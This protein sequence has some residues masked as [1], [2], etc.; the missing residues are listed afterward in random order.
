M[1]TPFT[2]REPDFTIL[3]AEEQLGTMRLNRLY[4]EWREATVE[5]NPPPASFID[6]QLHAYLAGMQMIFDVVRSDDRLRFRYRHVG[7]H[8]RAYIGADPTGIHLD[9]HPEPAF[10]EIAGRA[11]ALVVET[12][13]P[14]HARVK[15]EMNGRD[16]TVEFLVLPVTGPSRDV[17]FLFVAQ[18]FSPVE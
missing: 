11:C 15:R 16:F 14:V 9:E 5:S 4:R 1:A 3:V 13:R 18:L 8:I 6:P 2:S 10:A 7:S 17:D 12:R